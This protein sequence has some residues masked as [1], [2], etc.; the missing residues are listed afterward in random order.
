MAWIEQ[1]SIHSWRVRYPRPDGTG[2]GTVSC[3]PDAKTAEQYTQDMATDRRR[4]TW[5]DPTASKTTV[6]AWV[7]RW[8]LI[9]GAAYEIA[10]THQS[11][12]AQLGSLASSVLGHAVV[13][14]HAQAA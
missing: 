9:M 3:F 14:T 1:I 5:I 13:V 11:N 4:R 10:S 7:E 12:D 8:L 6:T 2:H